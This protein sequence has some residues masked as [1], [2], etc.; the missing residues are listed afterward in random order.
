MKFWLV[1]ILSPTKLYS[2]KCF[3]HFLTYSQPQNCGPEIV[4]KHIKVLFVETFAVKRNVTFKNKYT[5]L[6][7]TCLTY[8]ISC[9]TIGYHISPNAR[10]REAGDFP[11]DNRY[12]KQ[13]PLLTCLTY[14]QAI[15]SNICNYYIYMSKA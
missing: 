11:R 1:K 7:S 5:P 15:L 12:P 3:L 2:Q 13:V 8:G 6:S 4:L 14:L 10:S 9:H